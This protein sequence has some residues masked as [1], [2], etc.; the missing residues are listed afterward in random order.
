M[1]M[2]EKGF[3]LIELMIVIAIIGVLAAIAMPM[4]GDYVTKSQV[5]RV[6]GE[7]SSTKVLFE[8]AQLEGLAPNL[9]TTLT[10]DEEKRMTALGLIT[11]GSVPVGQA[12]ND[13]SRIRSNLLK[14]LTL[15]L[16]TN[17]S[18]GVQPISIRATL[19]NKASSSIEGTFIRLGRQ[20]DGLWTCTIN[21]AKA[22][23]WKNKFTPAG[24]VVTL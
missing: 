6:F 10:H 7:L 24:C 12:F 13:T 3:T 15:G 14:D 23:G 9:G 17:V 8:N 11:G 2:L 22:S 1:K 5:T 16:D 20:R 19:G 4:Y 18:K 21:A